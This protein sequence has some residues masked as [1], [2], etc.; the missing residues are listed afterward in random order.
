MSR[1]RRRLFLFIQQFR[2][3][4]DELFQALAGNGANGKHFALN[5]CRELLAD[6]LSLWQFAF[7]D[8]HNFGPPA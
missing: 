5:R 6:F 2:N 4:P 8:H 1:F 3:F 7:G